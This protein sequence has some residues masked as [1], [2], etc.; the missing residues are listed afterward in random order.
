MHIFW[1]RRR[2][3]HGKQCGIQMENVFSGLG[4]HVITAELWLDDS[5]Y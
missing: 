3:P 2:Y 5:N 1:E 4:F